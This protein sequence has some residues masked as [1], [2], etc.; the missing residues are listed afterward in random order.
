MTQS[1]KYSVLV[2]FPLDR[3]IVCPGGD[4]GGNIGENM[5]PGNKNLLVALI[6]THMSP[7]MPRSFNTVEV[8]VANVYA[9]TLLKYY[10][11]HHVSGAV[12]IPGMAVYSITKL[13]LRKVMFFRQ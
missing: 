8:I 12:F 5:V 1:K 10:K 13:T 2:L 6:Q 3:T 9:V 7:S 11:V 4:V